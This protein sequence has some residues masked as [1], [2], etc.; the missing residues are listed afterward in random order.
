[1][2]NDIN[3]QVRQIQENAGWDVG[4]HWFDKYVTQRVGNEATEQQMLA[5]FTEAFEEHFPKGADGS[6]QADDEALQLG[7]KPLA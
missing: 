2:T 6:R 1:M 5:A 4:P 7:A 3:A